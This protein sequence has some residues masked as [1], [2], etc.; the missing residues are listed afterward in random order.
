MP[1]KAIIQ[2]RRDT[3]ANWASTN[4]T[5]AAGEIGFE[6]N[7]NKFKFGTGST[8]WN[9]LAY[10]TAGVAVSTTAPSSP[11][12]GDIW[13]NST[14]GTAYIYYDGFWV[15]L[16]P[17]ITGPA[18]KFTV[19]ATAPSSPETG[20]GWFNSTTARLF[21][22]Y[23]SYWIEATSNYI[24]PTGP[25]GANG[26]NGATG[27]TGPT[28]P[29]GDP[30]LT[31]NQQTAS[32]TAVLA[33]ASKLVEISNSSATTFSIPTDASV[34]FPVGTQISILQTGTGQVTVAAVTSETTTVNA[35]PGLKLRA[36]WSAATL[37]K[38]AANLWVV[39][40]DLVA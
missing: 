35:T 20:D 13:Y 38:R 23:D 7:T 12:A 18:G 29:S 37:I 39:T 4:P 2:V 34:N 22:Y 10:T 16:N 24:G 33:D 5:L 1:A 31:I 8:A 25:A 26:T 17:G 15:D 32:Y 36:R 28:G 27:A 19:S 6:S 9:S 30:T 11:S 3:A 40:G 14:D 21:I